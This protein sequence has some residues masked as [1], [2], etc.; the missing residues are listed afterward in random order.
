M[1]RSRIL[2]TAGHIDHGKTALVRALTGVDTD[3]LKEEKERGITIDLG[4]AALEL[5]GGVRAGVVDVPGHEAFVRN[6]VAGA[7]GMDVVL[8]VVA[9]DEGVMPQTREHLAIVELLAVPRMVVA[10]TKADLVDE[11]WLELVRA[12]VEEVLAPTRYAAA[13]I[14]PVS[15]VT[16]EGLRALRG[17]LGEALC[18]DG[19]PTAA[20]LCRLPVDRVFTVQGT[21]T[22]VTGTLW[23]GELAV[24]ERV[25][26]LPGPLEARVRGLQVHGQEVRT[27][28][29][30]S[31]VAA[32]LAGAGTSREKLARGHVLVKDEGW[33][34]SWMLTVRARLAGDADRPL[35]HNQRVR[36]H[37]GTA[38]ILARCA[39]LDDTPFE[40]GGEGWIQLRLEEPTVARCGDR[41]VLRSYSPV[42]T[43][44]G[45]VV[46]EPTPPKRKSLSDSE[47]DVLGVLLDG[48]EPARLAAALSLGGWRGVPVPALAVRTGMPPAE[49][50]SARSAARGVLVSGTRAFAPEIAERAERNVLEAL[51]AYHARYGLRPFASPDVLRDALPRWADP[52]LAEGVMRRLAE[53]GEVE[54]V[55]GGIRDPAHTPMPTAEQ[56]RALARLE[57]VYREAGLAPPS[58]EELPDELASRD[59]L[60]ELLRYLEAR[61]HLTTLPGGR[62]IDRAV[63][64]EATARVRAELGGREGLGPTDFRGVLPVTRKHLMPLLTHLDRVGVTE[65]KGEL[66]SVSA[67]RLRGGAGQPPG[68]G[69]RPTS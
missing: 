62:F 7:T 52:W 54:I 41:I 17:A 46:V 31:R 43:I 48:D 60:W 21:G 36:V 40:P 10:V 30:G 44:G 14:L 59:D 6:M 61:G 63:L 55:R 19:A 65:R 28:T 49:V 35:E 68:A 50:E 8:L 20:D 32:A 38:E 57:H 16:H 33:S 11:E 4:F 51:E 13:P 27:A 22:V 24:G 53:R 45:G 42:T 66:R 3:R 29:A 1:T 26:V 5:D 12:E 67:R 47:R 37:L 58:P 25:R 64:G 23:S 15:A 18:E 39:L 9:A 2:G 69:R 56:G 34:E